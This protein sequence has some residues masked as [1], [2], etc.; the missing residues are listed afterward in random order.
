[1]KKNFKIEFHIHTISSKDSLLN[2]WFML[3]VLKLKRIN[4]IAITDHNEIKGAIKYKKFFEKRKINVIVGEEIFSSDGEII[5]LFLSKKIPKGMS[6]IDTVKE[7]ISQDGLVY[8]PHP[9]DEKRKNTV[10]S[11]LALKDIYKY[12]DF[13]E[14][15][16]GRNISNFFS[17]KQNQIAIK[18]NLRKIVGSDAHTFYELGRNYCIITSFSKETLKHEIENATFK[19][20]KCI[21]FAHFNTKIAKLIKIF[22]GGDINEFFTIFNRKFRKR[23]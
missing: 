10:I 9:Y 1:M 13:I 2:K 21:K 5:G 17:E 16:N 7:I 6:A 20:S 8:I 23:K 19:R 4:A 12:V 14:V 18:Y 22:F 15:H 11:E 3:F